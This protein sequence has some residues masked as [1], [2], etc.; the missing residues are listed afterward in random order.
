MIKI[1]IL[2]QDFLSEVH[3]G[4]KLVKELLEEKYFNQIP[5]EGAEYNSAV[6]RAFLSAGALLNDIETAQNASIQPIKLNG[7]KK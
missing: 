7:N 5:D 4:A 1:A 6:R 3:K 2:T